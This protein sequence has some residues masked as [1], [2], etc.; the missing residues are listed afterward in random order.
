MPAAGGISYSDAEALIRQENKFG[1]NITEIIKGDFIF[2]FPCGRPNEILEYKKELQDHASDDGKDGRTQKGVVNDLE[3]LG[4]ATSFGSEHW[5]HPHY[6]RLLEE[7]SIASQQV[8]E[9]VDEC[10]Y[11]PGDCLE[12]DAGPCSVDEACVSGSYS[13]DGKCGVAPKLFGLE[14]DA[15]KATL[16]DRPKPYGVQQDGPGD[17]VVSP[18]GH[19]ITLYGNT[20]KAFEIKGYKVSKRTVLEFGFK[21]DEIAEGHGKPIGNFVVLIIASV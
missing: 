7:P 5:I 4:Q 1:R 2:L 11:T 3:Y 12:Y 9:E 8:C 21:V 16:L 6:C 17:Y 10:L 19:D 18:N 13:D 14:K 15:A 20:W